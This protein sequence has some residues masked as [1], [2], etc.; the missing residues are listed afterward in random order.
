MTEYEAKIR[1]VSSTINE[2]RATSGSTSTTLMFAFISIML[3]K[4]KITDSDLEVI[5]DVEKNQTKQTLRSF[6]DQ[7]YGDPDFEL[8]N[9]KEMEDAI[10]FCLEYVDNIKANIKL[11]AEQL[12]TTKRKKKENEVLEEAS[13]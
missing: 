4:N 11:A 8:Q 9:E 13:E 12:S 6:F 2:M 1:T 10:K 7:H 3:A 5:F